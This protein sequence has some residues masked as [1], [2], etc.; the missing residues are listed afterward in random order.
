MQLRRFCLDC[1]DK[2]ANLLGIK[3]SM[4]QDGHPVG[5]FLSNVSKVPIPLAE[6]PE[7]ET[8]W[9]ESL[10]VELSFCNF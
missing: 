3:P 1:P 4:N 10:Q 9:P 2:L 5:F 6:I 8:L 7:V